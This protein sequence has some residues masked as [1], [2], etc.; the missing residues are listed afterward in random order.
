MNSHLWMF[1]ILYILFMN[2]YGILMM[3][4]DKRRAARQSYRVP[5]RR[6]F[7]LA[8]AG[9]AWGIFAGM[10]IFRHKTLHRRF[11]WGIPLIGLLQIGMVGL[12]WAVDRGWRLPETSNGL[13]RTFSHYL[14]SVFSVF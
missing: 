2:L 14:F 9:G 3:R 13:I 5:E 8:W 1:I 4:G 6:F 12:V 7:H 11:V 10:Y